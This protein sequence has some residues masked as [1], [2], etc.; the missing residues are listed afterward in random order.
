MRASK[1]IGAILLAGVMG[2]LLGVNIHA[3]NSVRAADTRRSLVPQGH[4]S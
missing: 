2:I 1:N 4:L 3:H